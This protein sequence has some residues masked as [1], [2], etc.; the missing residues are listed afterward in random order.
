MRYT[1]ELAL[2]IEAIDKNPDEAVS[3][4]RKALSQGY[5]YELTSLLLKLAEKDPKVAG[6]LAVEVANKL[7]E[8]DFGSEPE[9]VGIAL[10]FVADAIRSL[11]P[12]MRKGNK[13]ESDPEHLAPLLDKQF[14]REFMEFIVDAAIKKQPGPGNAYLLFNLRS[15]V[16][17]L[18]VGST[19][20]G[21]VERASSRVREKRTGGGLMRALP[22]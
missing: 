20:D 7:R 6:E 10:F 9:A 16:A 17:E 15:T 1:L 14:A 18:G 19:A 3:I 2:A 8:A 5:S 12:E 21:A 11:K 4:G 22:S 13:D